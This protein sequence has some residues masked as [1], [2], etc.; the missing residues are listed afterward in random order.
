MSH[1]ES[2]ELFRPPYTETEAVPGPG[3]GKFKSQ[4]EACERLERGEDYR[5]KALVKRKVLCVCAEIA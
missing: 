1:W 3:K 4:G 2:E 5:N